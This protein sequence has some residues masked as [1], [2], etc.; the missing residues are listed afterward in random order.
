[1]N[2]F[3]QQ[4]SRAAKAVLDA[5]WLGTATQ[6]SPGLYP[7]QWNWDS[8]FIALG[9]SRYRPERAVT[10]LQTLFEA[11]WS[12]GMLPHIVF[13]N[14]ATPD[15]YFPGASFW[16]TEL[17]P[18]APRAVSTSGITQPPVH[19]FVLL[20]LL[21][22]GLDREFVKSLCQKIL[23]L[24]RY[25]YQERDP[26]RTGLVYIRHPWE[27]GTANA[28]TWRRVLDRI[29]ITKIQLPHYE[30]TDLNHADRPSQLDFDRYIHI[31]D[32]A[33][34]AR[35]DEA[36]IREQCPFLVHDPLF[37]SILAWADEALI[38]VGTSVG[39]D[40][41]EVREWH[42]QTV[43]A[44]ESRLYNPARG[45]YD[46]WDLVANERI[47]ARHIAAF[48]PIICG[49]PD[50]QRAASLVA[51]LQSS[52]FA[53]KDGDALHGFP[54]TPFHGARVDPRAPRAAA[55]WINIS[56]LL[57]QGLERYGFA[58]EAAKVRADIFELIARHGFYEYFHPRQRLARGE[59]GGFG[60][61]AYSWSAALF[62][63][64]FDS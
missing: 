56:W 37:N 49:A 50:R 47:V 23:A 1:M 22:R 16:R 20:R 4:I 8:G 5:N 13:S 39:V 28:P 46:A 17:T 42:A 14:R 11:Q 36:R 27:S 54:L 3:E 58:R 21:E 44:L 51:R 55:V 57:Y 34:G 30:R 26:Q 12:N 19:G 61:G 35:Y 38:E 10:E 6:P 9:Y 41:G 32:L 43:R 33:R 63:D 15:H 18:H 59:G 62:L 7:H 45:V 25:L 60:G 29:D 48:S 2:P 24:H 52:G 40:I 53:G 31:A 64:L